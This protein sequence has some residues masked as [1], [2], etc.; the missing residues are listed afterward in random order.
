MGLR[1]LNVAWMQN[2]CLLSIASEN[3]THIFKSRKSEKPCMDYWAKKFG[4][5]APKHVQNTFGHFRDRFWAFLEFWI[6]FDFF[7]NFRRP[8][9]TWNTG[10]SLFLKNCQ[11]TCSKQVWTIL[12]TIFSIFAI[13][14]FFYF[15]ENFRWLH[16]HW[17]KKRF[18][19]KCPKT[20]L[21]TREQF[22]TFLELWTFCDFFMFSF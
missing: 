11:K 5:N 1:I 15:F 9:P 19:K 22:W 16:E 8:D 18:Q 21:G 7:E 2:E 3:W 17:A 13:L 4:K 20:R 6:F 14:H 12:G 10:H